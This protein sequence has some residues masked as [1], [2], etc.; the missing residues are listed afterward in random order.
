MLRIQ[1]Q[2][3]EAREFGE[4]KKHIVGHLFVNMLL[5]LHSAWSSSGRQEVLGPLA[6]GGFDVRNGDR[7]WNLRILPHFP[8][9][10]HNQFVVM[11][12]LFHC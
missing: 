10:A 8:I 5:L 2:G 4:W 7:I 1:N 3:A 11:N 6:K 12:D 9:N